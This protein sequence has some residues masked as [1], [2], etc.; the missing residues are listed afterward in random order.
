[1]FRTLIDR[2]AGLPA[3]DRMVRRAE[4]SPGPGSIFDRCL[5][6]A[7]IGISVSADDLARIPVRGPV[8]V[9]ANHPTGFAEGLGLPAVLDALR[10]DVHVLAHDFFSR[11]PSLAE[12]MILVDPQ[13]RGDR[14]RINLDGFKSAVGTL[15][16][17]GLVVLFPAGE[18]ARPEEQDW[19][20]GFVRMARASGATVVP[21]HVSGTTGPIHRLLSWIHPRLGVFALAGELKQRRGSRLA[22][23]VGRPVAAAD[24]PSELPPATVATAFRDQVLA[25]TNETRRR[26]STGTGAARSR[27]LPVTSTTPSS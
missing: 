23:R 14:R 21:V 17:G 22:L 1:M 12:R 26:R 2:L 10:D 20:S 6:T 19:Q 24:L 4:A 13:A 7:G 18:V 11:W 15:R 9:V 8:I 16:D 5:R 27:T 25:L 3:L